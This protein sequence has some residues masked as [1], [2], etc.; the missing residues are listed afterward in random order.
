MRK[1]FA[2][3]LALTLVITAWSAVI[4]FSDPADE[5]RFVAL[6]ER[7]ECLE[8]GEPCPPDVAT[9]TPTA[10]APT[11]TAPA[12]TATSPEPT[13]TEHEH[14]G[15][16]GVCGE[17]NDTWHA[18]R[19]NGCATGHE[20][21]TEPPSWVTASQFQPLFT[22]PANTPNENAFTHKHSAFK[23]YLL[24]DDGVTIYVIFH[25]DFNPGGHVNRFHS[26][27]L[28]ALD[29]SGNVSYWTGWLDFGPADLQNGPNAQTGPNI[30]RIGCESTSVRPIMAVNDEGCGVVQFESWYSRAGAAAWDFGFNNQ[31]TYYLGGDPANP[32]TWNDIN[33]GLNAVRRFEAAIYASRLTQRGFFY[34]TQFNSPVSGPNDP[35]C[36]TVVNIGGREY[37]VLCLQQYVAPT[38]T[39]VTFTGNSIQRT[40]PMDG[41]QLPN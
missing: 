25:N 34:R 6:E 18:G 28:W 9:A 2:L 37:T 38:M 30:R 36:G 24:T 13:A 23:G 17:S 8:N 31:P 41:V 22:H 4:A 5:E 11:A 10:P 7:V 16:V 1:F 35:V 19:V 20:H 39:P 26:Y 29:G 33:G 21:G 15:S 12:P 32:A 40:Y 27:Q 14:E 3:F